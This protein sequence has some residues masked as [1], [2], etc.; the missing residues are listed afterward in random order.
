[1]LGLRPA[2]V[3]GDAPGVLLAECEMED[4]VSREVAGDATGVVALNGAEAAMGDSSTLIAIGHCD[5]EASI[6]P[7]REEKSS[8][9]T[10]KCWTQV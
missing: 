1:M 7:Q 9:T 8:P 2:G 10:G 6:K 3:A 5:D 4:V